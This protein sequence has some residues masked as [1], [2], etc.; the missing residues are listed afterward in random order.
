MIGLYLLALGA[1]IMAGLS[2]LMNQPLSSDEPECYEPAVSIVEGLGYSKIPQQ[3]V[4]PS[5][6][7]TAYRM[8]GPS[9]V[10]ASCFAFF[11]SSIELARWISAVVGSLSAPFMYLFTRKFM[12]NT[13]ALLSGVA[14]ACYPTNIFFSI[15]ILSEP[16]FL[17]ALLLSL[18]LTLVSIESRS[19]WISLIVGIAW[20]FTTLIRPHSLPMCG[21]VAIYKFW[22]QDWRNASAT[23]LGAACVL[24]PWLTR[25]LITLGRPVL[26][27]T[28]GGETLLGANNP[29]VADD[30]ELRGMWKSPMSIPE[31]REHLAPI[32][33]EI[34]RDKEQQ[35]MAVRFISDHPDKMPALVLKKLWRWLTP[36]TETGGMVRLAVLCSYGLLLVLLAAGLFLG[37]YSS[38]PALHLVLLWT[39]VLF[40]ITCVY[41]GN[42]TRGRLPLE[43]VWLPFGVCAAWRI[44][45]LLATPVRGMLKNE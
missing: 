19:P 12:G 13:P 37:V 18:T 7:P 11:G 33:N 43:I 35:A 10:L 6:Q 1:R 4:D 25:N 44:C 36:V 34:D 16:Y 27:A 29:Y 39:L 40:A 22:R 26:L 5:C 17:P 41:W 38:S 30:P 28:E 14:C 45:G 21:L 42:L 2:L 23:V 20:G 8:P 24:T 15:K 9:L 3:A 32:Q 31:Y